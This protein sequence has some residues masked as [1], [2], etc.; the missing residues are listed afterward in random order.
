MNS[1]VK[2]L[3]NKHYTNEMKDL[4]K[5]IKRARNYEYKVLAIGLGELDEMQ[6]HEIIDFYEIP[7][8]FLNEIDVLIARIITTAERKLNRPIKNDYRKSIKLDN[9]HSEFEFM[10]NVVKEIICGQ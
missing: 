1:H 7:L 9:G 2:D 8:D 3:V 5:N 6:S 10:S 4:I